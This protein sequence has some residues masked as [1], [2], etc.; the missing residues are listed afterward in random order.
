MIFLE[1]TFMTLSMMVKYIWSV[2]L[3]K[4]KE[5]DG[6]NGCSWQDVLQDETFN[7]RG[8]EGSECDC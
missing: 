2:L 6:I 8:K 5:N 1:L 3:I 4:G 7:F